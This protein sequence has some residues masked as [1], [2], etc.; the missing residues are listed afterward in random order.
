MSFTRVQNLE[1]RQNLVKKNLETKQKMKNRFRSE[2]L[3]RQDAT[4]EFEKQYKPVLDPTK[5][6]LEETKKTTKNV[7]EISATTK[8]IPEEI[9]KIPT[10]IAKIPEEIAKI[11]ELVAEI[12]EP[13]PLYASA[14]LSEPQIFNEVGRQIIFKKTPIRFAADFPPDYRTLLLDQNIPPAH[15][16]RNWVK[17]VYREWSGS[18]HAKGKIFRQFSENVEKLKTGEGIKYYKKPE[19]IIF[20]LDKIAAAIDAGNTSDDL[21]QEG[22]NILD[23]LLTE[24]TINKQDY[25]NVSEFFI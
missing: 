6:I 8:Q 12:T 14:L 5:K 9:Q 13:P 25:K 21:K 3:R 1:E 20:R 11:P 24:G 15:A 4:V 18:K 7:K 22:I 2:K 19:E 16:E 17:W 23:K 10:E